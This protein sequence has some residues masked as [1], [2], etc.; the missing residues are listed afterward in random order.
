[1][2]LWAHWENPQNGISNGSA[3]LQAHEHDQQTD[4]Q[5]DRHVRQKDHA[6]PSVARPHLASAA[7]RPEVHDLCRSLV[8]L[9]NTFK[10]NVKKIL[11]SQFVRQF[12][13]K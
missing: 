3:I 11:T 4:R 5:T 9:D 10:S 8:L 1:M 7:T 12:V 13:P 6:T 2:V